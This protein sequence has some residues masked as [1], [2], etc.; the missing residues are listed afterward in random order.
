M[1]NHTHTQNIYA[2]S[3][4]NTYIYLCM[5][6][7]QS[8]TN[9]STRFSPIFVFVSHMFEV[10][11]I[12]VETVPKTRKLWQLIFIRVSCLAFALLHFVVLSSDCQQKFQIDLFHSDRV[13]TTRFG[14]ST[15][16]GIDP[17]LSVPSKRK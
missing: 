11:I 4:A 3:R 2:A 16:D 6:R 14:Q 5:C 17:A 15:S 9:A 8:K 1:S 10:E 13:S 12:N 7:V